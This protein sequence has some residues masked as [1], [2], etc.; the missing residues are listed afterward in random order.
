M[1][2]WK[3]VM[4]AS[5]GTFTGAVTHNGNV[6]FDGDVNVD[7]SLKSPPSAVS[8][9][10]NQLYTLD[11]AAATNF[12]LSLASSFTL[13]TSNTASCIGQT[14]VIIL[15]QDSTGGRTPTLTSD[16]Q[17]PRGD[18]ISFDTTASKISM[19]SYYIQASGVVFVNYMGKFGIPS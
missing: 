7:G 4:T 18:S 2:G 5:G 16:W 9:S 12:Q 8:V 1:A 3:K 19:L 15:I 17:T 11:F 6:D 14:G 10:A 13:G